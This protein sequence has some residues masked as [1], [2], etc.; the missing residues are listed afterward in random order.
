MTTQQAG[1]VIALWVDDPA[2]GCGERVF[3]VLSVGPK[4]ATLFSPAS[5][6]KVEVDRRVFDKKA[7][8]IDAKPRRVL[9]IL[10]RNAKAA[11]RLR[12]RYSAKM[13]AKAKEALS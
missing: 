10:N 3:V 6:D 8:T 5:L 4:W 13:V 7:T 12:R 11:K 2:I 9:A 1:P